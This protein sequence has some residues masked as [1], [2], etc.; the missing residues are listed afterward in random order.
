VVPRHMGSNLDALYDALTDR[1]YFSPV[2]GIL[3]E[4]E[5]LDELLSNAEPQQFKALLLTFSDAVDFWRDSSAAG[6]YPEREKG[7]AI[8][9]CSTSDAI[10]AIARIADLIPLFEIEI[11]QTG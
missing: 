2:D 10:S 1:D 7:N 3:L 8:I 6:E 11:R 4:I 9:N 5:N